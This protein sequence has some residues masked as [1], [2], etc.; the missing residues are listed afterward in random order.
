M[1]SGNFWT[2]PNGIVLD[3]EVALVGPAHT[4][5]IYAFPVQPMFS[6]ELSAS[7]ITG[8]PTN[9]MAGLSAPQV[10]WGG[11]EWEV[12]ASSRGVR[13]VSLPVDSRG[14]DFQRGDL[15]RYQIQNYA[16]IAWSTWVWWVAGMSSEDTLNLTINYTEEVFPY[17][18]GVDTQYAYPA[19]ARATDSKL[20]DENVNTVKAVA[21]S[22]GNAYQL[23]DTAVD[24]VKK[25]LGFAK[26]VAT[27]I[28]TISALFGGPTPSALRGERVPYEA[29][30]AFRRDIYGDIP[31]A[32]THAVEDE[33]KDDF[34]P[35]EKPLRERRN[36]VPEML[37]ADDVRTPRAPK[38]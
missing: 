9:P 34:T 3:I 6:T 21:S 36:T 1:Q 32:T 16:C 24:W 20:K 2:R 25:G 18:I 38:K 7:D 17:T 31:K 14:L 29:A 23:I 30:P 37:S 15:E 12:D 28:G 8:W 26:H 13:L 10:S 35:I 33:K 5:K 27:A 19:N 4:V 22:G 11:R